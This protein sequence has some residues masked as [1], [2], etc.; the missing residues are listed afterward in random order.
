MIMSWPV[1]TVPE[2]RR[3]AALGVDG[4]ISQS[5]ETLSAALA[6]PVQVAA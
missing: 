4:M 6:A 3:L 1:E 2:A 5:F